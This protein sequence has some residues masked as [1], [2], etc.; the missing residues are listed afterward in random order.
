[1]TEHT[2]SDGPSLEQYV[3]TRFN[4]HGV[5]DD[6][7]HASLL[8]KI[9]ALSA[10]VVALEKSID[11]RFTHRDEITA[12]IKE[13]SERATV[14]AE[15]AQQAHNV[16]ANEWRK[17]VQDFKDATTSRTEFNQLAASFSA[18]KLEIAQTIAARQLS[19]SA[20]ARG[21]EGQ[22]TESRASIGSLVAIAALVATLASFAFSFFVA[23]RTPVVVAPAP[24]AQFVIPPGYVLVPQTK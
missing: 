24:A 11:N 16:A 8:D 23:P 1:M 7:Q 15:Q 13:A 18:Y 20:A 21:A 19:D 9:T 3:E 2:H 22:R 14:K 5:S 17:T 10:V 12:L 6:K 4:L